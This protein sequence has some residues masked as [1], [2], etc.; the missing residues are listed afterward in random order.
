MLRQFRYNRIAPFVKMQYLTATHNY[1][2]QIGAS[3]HQPDT[4]KQCTDIAQENKSR[5]GKNQSS[6]KK[7]LVEQGFNFSCFSIFGVAVIMYYLDVKNEKRKQAERWEIKRKY[8]ED[9]YK[10]QKNN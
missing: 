5:I 8:L 1:I 10:L 7:I 4:Q 2:R 6:I 3:L 9:Q